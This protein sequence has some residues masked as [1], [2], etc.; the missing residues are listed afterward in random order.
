[1][2][3][4]VYLRD[5]QEY[6]RT[7]T[8]IEVAGQTFYLTQSQYTNTGPTTPIAGRVATGVPVFKSLVLLDPKKIPAQA[9]IKPWFCRSREGERGGGG[10]NEAVNEGVLP[11]KESKANYCE[12]S[13]GQ[14]RQPP[15]WPSG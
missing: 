9:G 10:G 2:L 4:I 14:S 1:M 12:R 7:H 8:E 15:R 6:V 11:P 3:Y 13:V 5:R